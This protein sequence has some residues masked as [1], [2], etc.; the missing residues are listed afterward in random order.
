MASESTRLISL[1]KCWFGKNLK[2]YQKKKKKPTP[3]KEVEY[4]ILKTLL[5]DKWQSLK[6][7]KTP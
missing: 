7:G 6:L 3:Q 4:L 5:P 1:Y 2:T